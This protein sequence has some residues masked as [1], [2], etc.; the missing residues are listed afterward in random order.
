ERVNTFLFLLERLQGMVERVST[1]SVLLKAILEETAYLRMLQEEERGDP[2]LRE[3][4]SRLEN[5][6]ELVTAAESF[7]ERYPERGFQDF[8]DEVSLFQVETGEGEGEGA[9]RLTLMT[10]HSAKG[11][12]FP[13]V[14]IAG[15]EEGV[16]PH[17]R[18]RAEA[19]DLEEERRL[20]YVGITRAREKLYLLSAANRHLYGTSQYNPE[21][22][23]L[24]EIPEECLEIVPG[25]TGG[26]R[27]YLSVDKAWGDRDNQ[28]SRTTRTFQA[29]R[30][31]GREEAAPPVRRVPAVSSEWASGNR[32]RHPVWGFG[33]IRTA[34]GQGDEVKVTVRFD[35]VGEKRLA[36]RYAKLERA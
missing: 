21:S 2:L 22:R 27:E 7:E 34:E 35:S 32:V 3:T 33:V 19:E 1:P 31:K 36:I 30:P 6:K 25:E 5:V 12:E 15:M 28:N 29:F 17:V 14:F 11:L 26:S 20:C 16:L 4:G 10:L 9:P 23:F 18:S 24:G 8:L 13:V